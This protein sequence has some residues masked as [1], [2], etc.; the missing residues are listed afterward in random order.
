MELVFQG[1]STCPTVV[2]TLRVTRVSL[3]LNF[4]LPISLTVAIMVGYNVAHMP[5]RT[6]TAHRARILYFWHLL[7][8]LTHLLVEST[9]VY[10]CFSNYIPVID[11]V[12]LS[13]SKVAF[14]LGRRDRLYGNAYG[15]TASARLWQEYAKADKRYAGIDL[16]TLSL[17]IITV[18]LAGPLALYVAELIQSDLRSN[19]GERMSGKTWFWATVLATGELYGG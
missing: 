8:G 14:F 6:P 18:F 4:L 11:Q 15:T 5:F 17:E 3:S 16:T 9:Y 1:A 19:T 2:M 7:D 10:N 13:T 12:T